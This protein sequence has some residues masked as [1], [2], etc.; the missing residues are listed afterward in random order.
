MLQILVV[1]GAL[2]LKGSASAGSFGIPSNTSR[3]GKQE[4][5]LYTKKR[6]MKAMPTNGRK[7]WQNVS[8]T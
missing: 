4:K 6:G 3:F 8:A 2:I 7:R 5:T 1:S